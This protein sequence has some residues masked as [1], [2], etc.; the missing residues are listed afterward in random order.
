MVVVCGYMTCSLGRGE[1]APDFQERD[2]T[3]PKGAE[4]CKAQ[5]AGLC[6]LGSAS[7]GLH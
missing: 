1:P 5:G 6:V 4:V 7:Q 3:S 2:G